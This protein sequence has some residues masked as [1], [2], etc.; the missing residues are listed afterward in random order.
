MMS[1]KKRSRKKMK[2]PTAKRVKSKDD[3]RLWEIVTD[4]A[5]IFD[6]HV[7]PKL[8][9]NDVKFFYDVNSESRAAIKRSGVRLADAFKIGDFDT[10]STISWALEKCI[11]RRERFCARMAENG[12]LEL[13]QFLRGKGCPWNARTCSYAALNGHFECLKYAHENGYPWNESTCSSA[14]LNGHL[15]C[16]KYLH[17]NGCPW[18]EMTCICAA[19]GGH[20]ECLKYAREN[21]CPWNEMTCSFAALE[22][23]LE[24]LK[25]AHENGCPWDEKTCSE[26][27][28]KGHFECLK[29]AHENGCPWDEETFNNAIS[30]SRESESFMDRCLLYCFTQECPGAA[31]ALR[32]EMLE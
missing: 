16:L 17:E 30:F 9:G 11:E 15:E 31:K 2:A 19:F 23:R 20:L 10:T 7:V 4:H 32:D 29:Y 8:N 5:D 6:T 18:N 1:K 24:C 13:L 21:G 27:A 25:Y 14:A 3:T 26:A 12:N 22:G 28:L